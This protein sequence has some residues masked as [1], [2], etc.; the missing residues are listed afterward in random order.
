MPCLRNLVRLMQFFDQQE[1]LSEKIKVI[2]NRLGLEDTQISLNKALET[3]GRDIFCQIPNDYPTMVESRNNG[4]PLLTQAPKA[5]LTRAIAQLAQSLD[6]GPVSDDKPAEQK[7]RKGLFGF[8]GT[9][10]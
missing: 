5:K 7:G 1:G 2:V 4:I 3:I 6:D 8:L 9:S 10:K